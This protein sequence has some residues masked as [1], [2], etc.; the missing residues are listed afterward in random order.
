MLI[1]SLTLVE[2]GWMGQPLHRVRSKVRRRKAEDIQVSIMGTP[3]LFAPLTVGGITFPHRIFVS[4]MC[5]YSSVDGFATD[6]HLVHL[7]SRAIGGAA[8]VMVEATAVLPEGRISPGDNGIWKDEHIAK[9]AQIVEFAHEHGARMGVQLAHAGRKAS[10]SRPWETPEHVV[11]A[12]DGGWPDDVVAPSAVAFS[13]KYPTPK[14]LDTAGIR[15]VVEAYAAAATRADRAGFD[16]VEIHAAHGYLLHEFYSPLSN[17]RADEYGG[18]FENRVRALREVTDAVRAVW[19]KHKALFVRI[20]ATD[21]TDGGWDIAQSVELAKLLH[22]HGVDLLDVSS[23]GNVAAAKIPVGPGYQTEFAA[24]IKRESGIVTGTVG[25]ITGPVQADTIIRTGQA[26]AVLLAREM[27]RDPYWP[28]HAAERLGQKISWPKQYLR[29]AH[30][31][32]VAREPV[33]AVMRD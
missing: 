15:R 29:A 13:E 21:W 1:D 32:T 28:L 12:P 9:L 6:W 27:L 25:M 14:A 22:T 23:G 11:A 31:D 17:S 24:R 33:R 30:P 7:G 8:L 3:H 5:Q 10:M 20:S 16:V 19:P 26:D 2:A 18:S 4:P